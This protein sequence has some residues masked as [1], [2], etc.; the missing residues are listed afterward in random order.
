VALI[1]TWGAVSGFLPLWV[2]QLVGDKDPHAKAN[3]QFVMSTASIVGCFVGSLLGGRDLRP[4]GRRRSGGSRASGQE[5]RDLCHVGIGDQRRG[6]TGG[7][8]LH[9]TAQQVHSLEEHVHA[10]AIQDTLAAAEPV[11]VV[12]HPVG[13]L[14]QL[15]VAHGR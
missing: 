14:G 10:L 1:G 2:D 15:L 3:I 11:Q 4:V 13:D 12:L 9:C 7:D 8:L 5:G 6:L